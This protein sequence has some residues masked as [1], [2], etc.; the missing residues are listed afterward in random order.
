MVQISQFQSWKRHRYA[1]CNYG[2][3]NNYPI[4]ILFL[5]LLRIFQSRFCIRPQLFLTVISFLLYSYSFSLLLTIC[6]KFCLLFDLLLFLLLSYYLLLKQLQWLPLKLRINFKILLLTLKAPQTF[7]PFCLWNLLHV[8][9]S[10]HNL[11]LA[12]DL[13]LFHP[14]H[15][16]CQNIRLLLN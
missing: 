16:L 7:S 9:G 1:L 3:H 15:L 6:S 8:Y 14:Y 2:I 5:Y 11:C 13:F 12:S 10:S 4:Y